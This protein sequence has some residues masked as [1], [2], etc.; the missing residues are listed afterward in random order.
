MKKYEDNNF[1]S[2]SSWSLTKPK[3]VT[4]KQEEMRKYEEMISNV[5]RNINTTKAVP[6]LS[7]ASAKD[8]FKTALEENFN[9]ALTADDDFMNEENLLKIE[10]DIRAYE[11]SVRLQSSEISDI[12]GETEEIEP[13]PKK[14]KRTV[15]S[16]V[17][18]EPKN[19]D[20]LEDKNLF[21]DGSHLNL[22]NKL[23]D[24]L[25]NV[26][27]GKLP[28]TSEISTNLNKEKKINIISN[29]KVKSQDKKE[30][31]N[32]DED[33]LFSDEDIVETTPQKKVNSFAERSV[34]FLII[35]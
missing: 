7:V 8:S 9:D 32:V 15:V 24:V 21:L 22:S 20:Q 12:I 18:L 34:I 28:E 30:E 27:M 17:N 33:D 13:L 26:Q 5:H 19:Q 31:V 16:K 1:S 35:K 29:V 14:R 4:P 2:N 23:C 10:N 3:I 25:E 6:E 11:R